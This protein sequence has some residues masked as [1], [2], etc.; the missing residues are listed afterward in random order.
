MDRRERTTISGT[1]EPG[2]TLI[3]ILIVVAI[4]ALFTGAFLFRIGESG[5]ERVLSS[6]SGDFRDAALSAKELAHAFRRD[7]YIVF[8]G[9]GF[10]L[11]D[12]PPVPGMV[13]VPSIADPVVLPEGV[14]A[15]IRDRAGTSWRDP[16]G[17]AWR[18]RRSGLNDPIEIR[19]SRGNSYVILDFPVLTVRASETSVF[20]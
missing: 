11:T 6:V 13:T 16:A 5:D 10:V 19:F 15:R 12:R 18:F 2:F 14:M 7:H 17:H 8:G 4:I 20:R 3:E 1:G 9:D